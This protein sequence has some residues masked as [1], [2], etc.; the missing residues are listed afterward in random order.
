MLSCLLPGIRRSLDML[1]DLGYDELNLYAYELFWFKCMF[2]IVW[3]DLFFCKA[4]LLNGMYCAMQAHYL[5]TNQPPPHTHL[6]FSFLPL[7]GSFHLLFMMLDEYLVCLVESLEQKAAEQEMQNSLSS[8]QNIQ[9]EK[10]Q[11]TAWVE[12]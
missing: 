3:A 11:G 1:Y 9:G 7:A 8:Y 10:R 12:L 4:C 6:L 2:I 5:I